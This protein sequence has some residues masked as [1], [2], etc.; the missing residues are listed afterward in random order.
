MPRAKKVTMAVDPDFVFHLVTGGPIDASVDDERVNPVR[1]SLQEKVDKIR[2]VNLERNGAQGLDRVLVVVLGNQDPAEWTAWPGLV[3]SWFWQGVPVTH[4]QPALTMA[5]S[6]PLPSYE[7]SLKKPIVMTNRGIL[8]RGHK[9]SSFHVVGSPGPNERGSRAC[10]MQFLDELWDSARDAQAQLTAYDDNVEVHLYLSKSDPE[11]VSLMHKWCKEKGVEMPPWLNKPSKTSA[12][13]ATP[14][15][16]CPGMDRLESILKPAE[17]ELLQTQYEVISGEGE[18][19][20]LTRQV[21]PILCTAGRF[22]KIKAAVRGFMPDDLF[23]LMFAA[24]SSGPPLEDNL[25]LEDDIIIIETTQEGFPS[26][27]RVHPRDRLGVEITDLRSVIGGGSSSH[28]NRNNAHAAGTQQDSA[29]RRLGSPVASNPIF[30]HFGPSSSSGGGRQPPRLTDAPRSRSPR[31][32]RSSPSAWGVS[33]ASRSPRRPSR[34]SPERDE[35]VLVRREKDVYMIKNENAYIRYL[36]EMPIDRRTLRMPWTPDISRKR[37]GGDWDKELMNWRREV[38]QFDP[39]APPQPRIRSRSRSPL[40]S[41]SPARK[42]NH[43]GPSARELIGEENRRIRESLNNKR[44]FKPMSPEPLEDAP[45]QTDPAVLEGRKRLL[46]DLA[47]NFPRFKPVYDRYVKAVPKDQRR[48]DMPRTPDVH[49]PNYVNSKQ[50]S[51]QARIHQPSLPD[52]DADLGRIGLNLAGF[53]TDFPRIFSSNIFSSNLGFSS[54][55]EAELLPKI[56]EDTLTNLLKSCPKSELE[57]DKV[58]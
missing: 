46:N 17:M 9:V 32:S 2:E 38:H 26:D 31:P 15:D 22:A 24:A 51:N 33:A 6:V 5:K 41:R 37:T 43:S 14:S 58:D 13:K 23:D 57:F 8:V 53:S 54:V 49:Q 55:F 16:M 39:N 1:K 20:G 45:K 40:R 56:S 42:R 36:Q 18:G 47:W 52:S 19:E 11:S 29:L 34:S 28:N 21:E 44:L 50:F 30:D 48:P 3:T 7:A 35:L 27:S 25:D 4:F 12:A 10:G